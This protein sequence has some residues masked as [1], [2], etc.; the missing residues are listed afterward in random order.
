MSVESTPDVSQAQRLSR[1][2][3]A[4][5]EVEAGIGPGCPA[6][7]RPVVPLAPELEQLLPEGRRRGQVLS[8]TGATS[9]MLA[10][11]SWAS[12]AGSWTAAIG[13]PTVGVV[14]AARRG[15]ELSRLALIPH[16]GAHAVE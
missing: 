10:L 16:P 4:R 8:V 2:R 5:K 1:A 9:L 7:D 3:A 13:M 11:A 12:A 6:W 14:A 15:I